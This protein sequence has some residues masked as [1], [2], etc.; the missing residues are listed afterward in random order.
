MDTKNRSKS[1]EDRLDGRFEGVLRWPDLDALWM[2]VIQGKK[3]WY[4]YEVGR[5]VPTKPLETQALTE[6]IK[7]IDSFLH[8][9]HDHD[10]CGVVY[11]DDAGDPSL[12]KV[13]DPNNLGASCGSGG[14]KIWPKY[15]LS[16]GPPSAVG[17][18]LDAE[19]KP[20]WW[21]TLVFKS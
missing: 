6:Q 21:K 7:S 20:A 1:F 11:V 2:R 14:V 12:I 5:D 4:V 15:I 19:G 13:L 18:K 10:Y 16:L 8:R 9:E 17:E 3:P